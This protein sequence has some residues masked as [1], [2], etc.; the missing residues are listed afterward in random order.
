[1]KHE[2]NLSIYL[3]RVCPVPTPL[4]E[5]E[6]MWWISVMLVY[7]W[8]DGITKVRLI[9][10]YLI[11]SPQNMHLTGKTKPFTAAHTA[12]RCERTVIIE[13][14]LQLATLI[15]T[16]RFF[17]LFHDLRLALENTCAC[18]WAPRFTIHQVHKRPEVDCH[19][20]HIQYKVNMWTD[21]EEERRHVVW[22]CASVFSPA[23]TRV[24]SLEARLYKAP[25]KLL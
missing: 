13:G 8:S 6:L 15:W 21:P 20:N 23:L 7:F 9:L 1:M 3:D 5:P 16:Q 2:K 22:K 14:N 25:Y 11:R 17:Y 4:Q 19:N 10:S 24:L 18:H 12:H